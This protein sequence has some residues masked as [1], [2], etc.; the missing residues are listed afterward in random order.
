MKRG[1]TLSP[2]VLVN[3]LIVF[4][5]LTAPL[6]LL[7]YCCRGNCMEDTEALMYMLSLLKIY[8]QLN[9]DSLKNKVHNF[10]FL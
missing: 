1:K 8:A 10:N 2:S 7:H 5:P 4:S 3:G 9:I 6:F